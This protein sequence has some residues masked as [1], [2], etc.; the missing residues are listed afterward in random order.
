METDA[1]SNKTLNLGLQKFNLF[2]LVVIQ[3]YNKIAVCI[4][5]LLYLAQFFFPKVT[6]L[7]RYGK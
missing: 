1:Y 3:K 4:K 7:K 6:P 2:T 5:I